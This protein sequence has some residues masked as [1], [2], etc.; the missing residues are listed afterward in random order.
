FDSSIEYLNGSLP[1]RRQLVQRG[2]ASLEALAKDAQGNDS[3]ELDLARAYDKASAIQ[4]S[5][6][7]PGLGDRDGALASVRRALSIRERLAAKNSG[8]LENQAGIGDEYGRLS[9]IVLR[10][11]PSQ[12]QRYLDQ[13]H[14][15]LAGLER[16]YPGHPELLASL[17]EDAMRVGLALHRAGKLQE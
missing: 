8:G 10:D 2:L 9:A 11:N 4:W 6:I 15:I 1:A 16:Q 3:L 7:K 14:E 12:S 5:E 13:S 17:L